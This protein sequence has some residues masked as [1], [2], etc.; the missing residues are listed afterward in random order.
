MHRDLNPP[1][2]NPKQPK[3]WPLAKHKRQISG[4]PKRPLF[5]AFSMGEKGGT[6]YI[7]TD[8]SSQILTNLIQLFS[9]SPHLI[10][11]LI[12]Q[13]KN[14]SDSRKIMRSVPS[15]SMKDLANTEQTF[16]EHYERFND[17]I[18][19]YIFLKVSDREKAID[20]TQET[21]TRCYEYIQRG[22]EIEHMKSLLYRIA[23]NLVIDSYRKH[24]ESSLDGLLEEGFDYGD[25]AEK[26]LESQ[27]DGT[28]VL[29]IVET[30]PEKYRDVIIMRYVEDM[31]VKEIARIVGETENTVSVR[32]H[33]GLEQ[34]KKIVSAQ[35]DG[36]VQ[37]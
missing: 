29:D 10:S 30:L 34:I 18:F 5:E 28:K 35:E 21:F 4:T 16:L 3:N 31:S 26:T 8:S 6:T 25:D 13:K 20:L 17:A 27:I 9:G 1:A 7:N 11:T 33:R 22:T 19:R 2:T 32:I 36:S 12:S 23:H 37:S 24:K 14:V 15:I